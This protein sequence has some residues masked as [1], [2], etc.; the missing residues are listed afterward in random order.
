MFSV[1]ALT[2]G[3]GP[4]VVE[5]PHAGLLIDEAAA[6]FTRVPEGVLV[7]DSDVGAD[8]VFGGVTPAGAA[9]VVARVSR[10]VVDLNTEPRVPTAYQDKLPPGLREIRRRSANGETWFEDPPPRA[11]VERRVREIFEPYH[12]A[13]AEQLSRARER[14]GVAVLVSG[15]SYPDSLFPGKAD[16]VVGTCGGTTATAPFRDAVIDIARSHG[17][18]VGV[19]EPF[20]GGVS[21]ARHGRP[22]QGAHALQIEIARRIYCDSG[23]FAARAA[24]VE[25][26]RRV[27]REMVQGLARVA[28]SADFSAGS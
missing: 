27:T 14:H 5:V 19:E 6:R 28:E 16:V 9:L 25:R 2:A 18:T 26:L 10:F 7:A 13:I 3:A 20:P 8:E 17:L 11:E 15:H 21:I 4:V 24:D 22:D 1:L 12:A 23:T